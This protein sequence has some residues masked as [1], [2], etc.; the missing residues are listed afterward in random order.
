MRSVA[1]NTVAARRPPELHHPGS[2]DNVVDAY[3]WAVQTGNG[4]QLAGGITDDRTRAREHVEHILTTEPRAELGTEQRVSMST[5]TALRAMNTLA[6]WPPVG[7]VY[8]CVRPDAAGPGFV[9]RQLGSPVLGELARPIG[10]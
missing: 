10:P 1:T 6:A 8:V 7:S 2:R 3:T 9:W 5:E 4:A